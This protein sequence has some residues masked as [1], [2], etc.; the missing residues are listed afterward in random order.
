MGEEVSIHLQQ[1]APFQDKSGKH[2]LGEVHA[3]ADL[4]Q[5][6]TDDAPMLLHGTHCSPQSKSD[7]VSLALTFLLPLKPHF[8][9]PLQPSSDLSPSAKATFSKPASA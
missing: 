3:D 6:V 4:G 8:Q 9:N 5:Q 2:D 7:P 1:R